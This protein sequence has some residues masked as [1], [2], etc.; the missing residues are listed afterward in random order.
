ML[1]KWSWLC[2][3]HKSQL[4]FG[5]ISFAILGDI[6]RKLTYIHG[7]KSK[8]Y[9]SFYHLRYLSPQESRLCTISKFLSLV[10]SFDFTVLQSKCAMKWS[11]SGCLK[12]QEGKPVFLSQNPVRIILVLMEL[13]ISDVNFYNLFAVEVLK[14]AKTISALKATILL[15]QTC[16]FDK[17]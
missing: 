4:Y 6:G 8:M 9:F 17:D 7:L 10:K 5:S 11:F 13:H 2:L 14:G 12:Q 3:G 1:P 15:I 16:N